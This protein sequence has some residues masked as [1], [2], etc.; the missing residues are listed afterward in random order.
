MNSALEAWKNPAILDAQFRPHYSD[1]MGFHHYPHALDTA[2][3]AEARAAAALEHGIPVVI[4][5]LPSAGRGHDA[6]KHLRPGLEH[7]FATSEEYAMDVTRKI[8]ETLGTPEEIQEASTGSIATTNP[9]VACNTP[10]DICLRQGDL[11]AGGVISPEPVIM[12]NGTYRLF[13]EEK[14]AKGEPVPVYYE[15][16]EKLIREFVE[17]GGRSREILMALTE[18]LTLGDH[19][20]DEE[21]RDFP[22]QAAR[23]I[24]LLKP[25]TM[26]RIL[27]VSLKSIVEH[28]PVGVQLRLPG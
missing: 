21:G 28:R 27:G 7:P 9:N 8:L 3:A 26:E 17:F 6:G 19:E 25:E 2:V 24:A 16:P 20:R 13:T 4:E 22:E 15:E 23:N 14:Q 10:T 1:T 5:A 18:G 11:T 12:L